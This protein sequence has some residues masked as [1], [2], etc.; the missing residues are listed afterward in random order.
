MSANSLT[1]RTS[2]AVLCLGVVAIWMPAI[3]L[4]QPETPPER[5]Q[6]GKVLGKP[7]YRNQI[8]TDKQ[9][10][11]RS[12]LHR[13]FSSEVASKYRK[14]HADEIVP[15]EAEIAAAT[16]VF[17]EGHRE[18]MRKEEPELRKKQKAIE[19][20]LG[21]QTLSAEQRKKLEIDKLVVEGQLKPPGRQFAL[22][23]LNNWKFQKYLYDK[24]GGGRILWQQAGQEA[25]DANRKWLETLEKR[26]DFEITDPK[27]RETFYEYWTS[28]KHGAF[29]TDDKERIRTEFLEPEWLGKTAD[30]K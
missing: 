5:E 4:A 27:L 10:P 21:D 3:V 28:M 29:L 16:K 8:R 25:F 26:G 6:I 17:D 30:E 7:V 23:I 22:F 19:D 24:Y 13:L 9:H 20:Q 12:E 2:P 14:E 11:L 1:A 18:R 15:T